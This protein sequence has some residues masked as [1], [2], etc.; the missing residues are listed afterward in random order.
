[1]DS[2]LSGTVDTLRRIS[3]TPVQKPPNQVEQV[4]QD[5]PLID[6]FPVLRDVTR[7]L[8]EIIL[9]SAVADPP[10]AAA[11]MLKTSDPTPIEELAGGACELPSASQGEDPKTIKKN[12][13]TSYYRLNYKYHLNS[14][15][16][17]GSNQ[18]DKEDYAS[19]AAKPTQDALISMISKNEQ[20]VAK[21]KAFD[22]LDGVMVPVLVDPDGYTPTDW[23]DFDMSYNILL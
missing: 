9:D 12:K 11:S 20:M 21:M 8:S 2:F 1:M 18:D 15:Q 5:F 22:L 6:T 14:I 13:D 7:N 10:G 17:K 19:P 3:I 23:W 16:V 4:S